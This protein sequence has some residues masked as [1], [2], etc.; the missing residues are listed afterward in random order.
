M[1]C[2]ECDHAR[3]AHRW[4]FARESEQHSGSR[5]QAG[6]RKSRC[7]RPR[8][9]AWSKAY[10][11]DRA[12]PENPRMRCRTLR[13]SQTAPPGDGSGDRPRCPIR[14][15]WTRGRR[16]S[17]AR[18]AHPGYPRTRRPPYAPRSATDPVRP[19]PAPRRT[20]S[21]GRAPETPALVGDQPA[22][23]ELGQ[24]L[25]R[26]VTEIRCRVVRSPNI[27]PGKAHLPAVSK[28]LP[29]RSTPSTT[30]LGSSKRWGGD[31]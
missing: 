31:R 23:P 2:R 26:R 22:R 29:V 19:T 13:G 9:Y 30:S 1:V 24:E 8:W 20:H 18:A 15:R 11:E 5:G 14:C 3:S 10:D 16:A 17:G 7:G 6:I 28:T 25:A 12:C 4:R 27:R 21:T